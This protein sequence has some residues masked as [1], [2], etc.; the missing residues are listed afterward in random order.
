MEFDVKELKE[1]VKKEATKL[2]KAATLRERKRLSYLNLNPDSKERCIYG[3]MTKDCFSIRA[4]ELIVQC[5]E[6]VLEVTTKSMNLHDLV[7]K[8]CKPTL[9]NNTDTGR[10]QNESCNTW[11]S[12]IEIFISYNELGGGSTSDN[13]K[14]IEYLKNKRK[15]LDFLN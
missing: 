9:D 2:K 5:C 12:P 7:S 14:L 13:L 6:E 3:Q 11:Y 4:N 8:T 15:N 1:L 10:T